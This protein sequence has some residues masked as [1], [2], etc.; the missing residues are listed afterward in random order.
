MFHHL[1]AGA[2]GFAAAWVAAGPKRTRQGGG[3]RRDEILETIPEAFVALDRNFQIT[4]VNEAAEGLMRKSREQLLGHNAWD[5]YPELRGSLTEVN[6]R[7]VLAEQVPVHF[8]SYDPVSHRWADVGA[9][10][11][12][13]G[14]LLISF[15]E[16]TDKKA[17][18]A[19]SREN[20]ERFRFQLEAANV[21]TWEWNIVTG[22]DRWSDNMEAIHGMAPGSFH[23]NIRDMMETVY[24]ADRDMVSAAVRRA[25]E[26]HELYEVEYRTIGQDGQIRWIEAKGRVVYDELTGQPLRMIGVG[27]NVTARKAS[28][29]ALRDSEERFRTLAKHVPVGIFLSDRK[30]SCV[31]V[32]EHWSTRTGMSLED[33]AGDGWLRAV[34]PD[35][36]DNVRRIRSE[37]IA[38]GRGYSVTYR[39]PTPDGK[40]IWAETCASPQRNSSGEVTGYLGTI[41]DVTEH[42]LWE[43]EL[44]QVNR[45]VTD[46]LESITE[47]FIGLDFDWRFTYANQPTIRRMRKSLDQVLGKNIWELYPMLA[48]TNFQTQLQRVMTERVPVHFEFLGPR[49]LWFDIHAYPSNSGLSAYV[50]DV[51]K[52]KESEE[53]LSRL[54]AIVDA[55][56][57]AIMSLSPD[58]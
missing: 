51:T 35:D 18:E 53:E 19:A 40:I 52:R 16:I 36:R 23:G 48:G 47:M 37:A 39:I 54:A 43:N 33:S 24:P 21:G 27:M 1:A 41:V 55:S 34:H 3:K 5:V 9:Y 8:E 32:N 56:N 14:G 13:G 50:L 44:Q 46:V 17:A 15:R 12:A 4:F 31:F 25:F 45:Q 20:E 26:T 22:E 28:E 11:A 57:D 49:N 30:G 29:I 38:E 7:R 10:P 2:I 58:G 42:K 6:C